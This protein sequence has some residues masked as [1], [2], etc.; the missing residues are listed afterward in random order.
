M[1]GSS[2]AADRVLLDA[3]A[4]CG[5]LV[6]S[7][8]VYAFLAE[9]RR[10][11]F[12]DELFADLFPSG[13]GRPSIPADVIATT[14]VLKEL[15]GL[16]DRQ[17]AAALATALRW[18]AAAGLPLG[19]G[20]FGPS[21]VGDWRGRVHALGRPPPIHTAGKDAA[22]QARV[23]GVVKVEPVKVEALGA[24][25]DERGQA[26]DH[27]GDGA[28]GAVGPQLVGL[29]ADGGGPAP[30]GL[31]VVAAAD[32]ERR[33][34]DQG[35]R[36]APGKGVRLLLRAMPAVLAACPGAALLVIGDQKVVLEKG[37]YSEW[38]PL[39]FSLGLGLRMR[40]ICRFRLLELGEDVLLSE[41]AT[42]L[43]ALEEL[44]RQ[45]E[46]V[47]G[48]PAQ[49]LALGARA[50]QREHLRQLATDAVASLGV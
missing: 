48:D 8:S 47:G 3:A 16:S 31:L 2:A 50:E 14:M 35:G 15:E 9:H 25:L 38:V 21:A 5:H 22:Q 30:V 6:P 42:G 23:V 36:V 49:L 1:Q 41:H 7:G 29:A 45:V 18:K 28:G 32:D 40:G 10:G 43:H 37:E 39:S 20:A 13:R 33:R 34:H 44:G 11:I 4:L 19:A 24:R 12:P 26:V 46:P 17:A 27:L